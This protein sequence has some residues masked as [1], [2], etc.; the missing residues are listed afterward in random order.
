MAVISYC[1]PAFG[2]GTIHNQIGILLSTIIALRVTA[3]AFKNCC[4]FIAGKS[5]LQIDVNDLYSTALSEPAMSIFLSTK[6]SATLTAS[7]K[8]S[9]ITQP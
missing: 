8:N 9:V 4:A 3:E 7:V 5:S 6:C 1:S 2:G